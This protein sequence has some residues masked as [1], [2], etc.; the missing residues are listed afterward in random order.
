MISRYL[1]LAALVLCAMQ[2]AC[3]SAGDGPPL[4]TVDVP[5]C[6]ET[7]L[8]PDPT[9]SDMASLVMQWRT[10]YMFGTAARPIGDTRSDGSGAAVEIHTIAYDAE[11]RR[12]EET[13]ENADGEVIR[14]TEHQYESA[15]YAHTATTTE[16][17]LVTEIAEY[18]ESGALLQARNETAGSTQ[19]WS[20]DAR[21]NLVEIASTSDAD[22][23]RTD[24]RRYT[25]DMHDRRVSATE[26]SGG[27]VRVRVDY[28]YE[29]D[30]LVRGRR[31]DPATGATLE[32]LEYAYDSRGR[33]ASESYTSPSGN[34]TFQTTW[35][36]ECWDTP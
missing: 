36:Y 26:E 32:T 7:V 2:P 35:S 5:A 17:G 27:V 34:I 1:P 19:T 15:P 25:Y 18:D 30:R 14:R 16:G 4:E 13:W 33:V 11:G 12:T 8:Y 21:G 6:T 22:P 3:S 29:G 9:S 31:V 20:Y 23:G 24:F 10:Q 28:E